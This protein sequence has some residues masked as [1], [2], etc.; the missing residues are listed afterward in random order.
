MTHPA[1]TLAGQF[2]P[3]EAGRFRVQYDTRALWG[4]MVVVLVSG[5]AVL[6][7]LTGA[8]DAPKV[9]TAATSDI[10]QAPPAMTTPTDGVHRLRP[11]TSSSLPPV[12]RLDSTEL[13]LDETDG[14]NHL[15]AANWQMLPGKELVPSDVAGGQGLLR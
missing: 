8:A 6:R 3:S 9:D 10:E 13:L 14:W 7:T 5:F 11:Q 15:P 1:E 2:P 12:E 4:V